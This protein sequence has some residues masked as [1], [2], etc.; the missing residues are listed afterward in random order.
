MTRG[1][2]N[3]IGVFGDGSCAELTAHVHCREC[4]VYGAAAHDLLDRPLPPDYAA[5]RTQHFAQPKPADEADVASVL[6]FRVQ[7]EWFGLPTAVVSEVTDLRPV[8]RLPHRSAGVVVGVT[9]IRGELLVCVALEALLH[10]AARPAAGALTSAASPAALRRLLVLRR[11][12]LRAVC[13]V[14]EIHGVYRMPARER[15]PVPA[16]VAKSAASFSRDILNWRAVSVGL[17][18]DQAVFAALQRA[19]A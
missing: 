11:G 4:P 8:H 7:G 1:C 3:R 17:L 2:W 12:D 16:T 13:R 10:L 18:D 5:E 9:N 14:D 15:R 19:L 6:L